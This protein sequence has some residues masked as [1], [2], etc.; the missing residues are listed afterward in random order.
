[1]A[2]T[3]KSMILQAG[4]ERGQAVASW[5]DTP[6]IG[7]EY[8][9]EYDGD[10]LCTEDNIADIWFSSCYDAESNGRQYTPF[11]FTAREL[12]NLQDGEHC[13]HFAYCAEIV[14]TPENGARLP[15]KLYDVWG[16]FDDGI[17]QGIALEWK[18][19]LD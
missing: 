2:Q 1:M 12:N 18:T 9:T 13:E 16:V 4:I 7:V 5:V 19:R 8:W 17:S 10:I 3:H 11:E 15:E 14:P 6:E